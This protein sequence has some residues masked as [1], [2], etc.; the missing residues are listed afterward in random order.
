MRIAYQ[1]F[2]DPADEG[3]FCVTFPDL[4]GAITEGDSWEEAIFNAEEV[5]NAI[6]TV[7]MEKGMEIP[8]PK[9]YEKGVWIYPNPQ[10]QAALLVRFARDDRSLADL[11]RALETSWPAAKRLED[12]KN[13]PTIKQL[14]RAAKV[15]GKRLVL[16]FESVE[17]N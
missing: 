15:L 16:S 11:A 10:V 9:E 12:P 13:S 2:F 4:P 1:A 3:G 17:K 14:A 8:T 6:L 7:T 5:L